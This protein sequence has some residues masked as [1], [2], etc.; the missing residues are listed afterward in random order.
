MAVVPYYKRFDSK[1]RVYVFVLRLLIKLVPDSIGSLFQFLFYG[2]PVK[3]WTLSYYLGVRFFKVI[4][5]EIVKSDT[6]NIVEGQLVTS[7]P[8]I[9]PWDAVQ[10]PET[11]KTNQKVI[12]F[13]KVNAPGEWF[14]HAKSVVE[15]SGDWI[16]PKSI[17]S[18]KVLYML[19]GGGLFLGSSNMYRR[20]AYKC[21]KAA[22]AKTFV[23]NYRLAPQNPYP[24]PIIDCVSGYLSLLE[25]HDASKIVFIGDS[26]DFIPDLPV[27]S[28][29]D[30]RLVY[31]APNQL[32]KDPYVS[33][34]YATD[35][36]RLPPLLIQA[37]SGERLLDC[38]TAFAAKASKSANSSVTFEVYNEHVHVFHFL[39][40]CVELVTGSKKQLGKLK[41][42]NMVKR[43]KSE[44]LTSNLAQ[45]QNLIKR[46]PPSYTEEFMTQYRHFESSMAIF[47]MKPDT[48][49]T[50]FGE[51]IMF[52]SA[53]LDL[54]SN[55]YQLMA[56]ELRK[57]MVQALILMRNRDLISQTSLLSLFFT[58]FRCKD[59]TLRA[60]LHSHIVS[61]IK[62][63]NAKAKNNK[64]NKTM[65][66]FMYKMLQDP[67]EI[68][69]KKSLE[70][71]I[72][73]YQ[74]N[75]WNDAK[76]VNVVAEACLS[77]IPK[78]V[79]PALHFFLGTN[80]NKYD[81][82][83]EE[84][85][86]DLLRMKQANIVNK[87]RKSRQRQMDKAQALVRRK[88]RQKNRAEIFNF[89]ALH[90]LNDPQGF[91]DNLFSRLKQ[92][93]SKNI[94][95]FELR[96]EMMNLISRLIGV[97]KLLTLGFYDFMI[98]YIKPHQ[99][100]VTQILAY[101]AQ[102]SHEL[103]PPDAMESVVRAIADNFVWSN[104]AS[105]V[106]TAGLNAL[107]EICSRCPLAM[108]EEL[109]KSLLEDYKNH[110]EKGPMAAARA[111]LS[112]FREY[113][114]EM[115]KKKDRGKIA[116]MSMKDFKIQKYGEINVLGDV[117]DAELLEMDSDEFEGAGDDKDEIPVLV[118]NAENDDEWEDEEENNDNESELDWDNAEVVGE[119]QESGEEQDGQSGEEQEDLDE[120]EENE[121]TPPKKKQK[122]SIAA[123]KIFTDEDFAKIRE[124]KE[125]KEMDRMLGHSNKV[126]IEADEDRDVVDASKIM[127]FTKKKDD[128]AARMESIKEG[129][130]GRTYGSKRGKDERSSTTN[131]EK[132]KKNKP[133]TM[134]VHKRAVKGK[135]S[136]S[137][138]E[139]QR[140]LRAHITK[141]KKKG[142]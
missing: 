138:M 86:P 71:M 72:E 52:I 28:R 100:N 84:E 20:T 55:H 6:P 112:L 87:K 35:F 96:L 65:Q 91:A 62:N 19:H 49:S 107:R 70:V 137:L 125:Q 77:Q 135:K 2:P 67:S 45:L 118:P 124:R 22:N 122:V 4:F 39:D 32:L 10:I 11:F 113:N 51:Q 16:H 37:G 142:F 54:L 17:E 47:N 92:V 18:D 76:T 117:E 115:L 88:E 3:S 74:K 5:A 26:A 134:L 128:Y 121:M 111:L 34:V 75:V 99:K 53:V 15:T 31:Y 123:T 21:A 33:P 141:Q 89:S 50:A 130:E 14:P 106:V 30:G 95:N 64:L 23:V 79:A 59:K 42:Q 131:R 90:L 104:C 85:V 102:A 56:P 103:V 8:N 116:S 69:A 63:A 133:M 114:P 93:S 1:P 7:M 38:I 136:R 25:K 13:I 24:I 43:N 98:S 80:D 66:N 126:L 68:A 27:D 73:L 97:H 58:L 139:K 41:K 83:D 61:D 82:D 29:G 109:L 140:V 46:D 36:T 108:P 120:Q 40:Y 44:L 78:L 12:D 94:F 132:S 129:R 101:L 105:E 57:T 60:L 48:E 119:E 9:V 81:E 110:K 127:A